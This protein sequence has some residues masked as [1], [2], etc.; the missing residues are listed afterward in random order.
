M[1]AL[2]LTVTINPTIDIS[3]TTPV[4]TPEHKLRCVGV[5][6]D[7]GGGGINVARVL[8]RL[9]ADC[10]ALYPAGGILGRLLRT[11]LAQEGIAGI[12]VDVATETRE[13]FTVLEGDTGRE[14]RFVLPG[15]ELATREWQECIERIERLP[16]APGFIVASGSLPPGVPDDFYARLARIARLRGS[17]MFLD[18]SGPSLAAALEEGVHLIKPNLRELKLLTGQP[19]ESEEAWAQAAGELVHSGRAHV[20]ALSL[21]HRGALLAASRLRLRAAAMSVKIAST[22]GAGDSFLAGLVWRLAAGGGLEEAF[23][24][25]VASGTAALLT[26]GTALA[27][28]HDIERLAPL[29]ELRAIP[30]D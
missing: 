15:P 6:R 3:A 11:L 7:P 27:Y 20:V 29:V 9:G 21:G 23:R 2:I 4:V 13:S 16:E 1:N 26:P 14:F 5:Q 25:A 12:D 22:V 19:L 8:T 18:A 17:R 24:Y 30:G 28:R 10:R